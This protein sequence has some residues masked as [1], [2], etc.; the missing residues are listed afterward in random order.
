MRLYKTPG[1]F[2]GHFKVACGG[3]SHLFGFLSLFCPCFVLN[4][5]LP[6]AWRSL[7]G[8]VRAGAIGAG[9]QLVALRE[10]RHRL[11]QGHGPDRAQWTIARRQVRG[12]P[13]QSTLEKKKTMSLFRP[14][15]GTTHAVVHVLVA[16]L[17]VMCA[18]YPPATMADA[19]R[20]GEGPRCC[21]AFTC[22][23]GGP[24]S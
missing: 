6:L 13:S 2:P 24:V 8:G 9:S 12:E 19:Y 10:R 15:C 17:G 7:Q 5:S 20:H 18:R 1:T 22:A 3:G 16:N 14:S 11:G 23:A 21:V 4:L